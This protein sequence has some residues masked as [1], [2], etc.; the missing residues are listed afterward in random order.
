ME[1]LDASL[2]KDELQVV[3]Q[4]MFWRLTKKARKTKAIKK[5]TSEDE[6]M[7]F[8]NMNTLVSE[9]APIERERK[10]TKVIVKETVKTR[11]T[12]LSNVSSKMN[13]DHLSLLN[14]SFKYHNKIR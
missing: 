3:G 7:Q 5:D 11:Q 1:N 8:D 9:I 13:F 10:Q 6:S 4:Q 2:D 12:F 14:I